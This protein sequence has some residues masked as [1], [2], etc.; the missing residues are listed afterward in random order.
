MLGR[1]LITV[2]ATARHVSAKIREELKTVDP[3]QWAKLPA[4]REVVEPFA[5]EKAKAKTRKVVAGFDIKDF[6]SF[7]GLVIDNETD[8]DL[9]H[10]IRLTTCPL[11]GEAHAG[12]NSTTC[13]FIYPCK[14]GGIAYHCQ[15]TGCCEYGIQEVLESLAKE[16]G[17]YPKKIYEEK[18]EVGLMYR[19]RTLADVEEES[20]I[21]LWPGYLFLK[22]LIHSMG[23]SSEGKSPCW[24]DVIARVTSGANWPDGVEN[25]LGSASVILMAA[26]DDLSD[27]VKP[28]IRLAGGDVAKV[29]L[30]EVLKRK[31]DLQT[32]ISVAIDR[33]IEGSGV[34]AP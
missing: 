6:L 4:E 1:N 21:P 9:G 27:T 32:P 33:D 18:P 2:F 22:Q 20:L 12:H 7:Y 34:L 14:D 26:E 5:R 23:A 30:F 13:N 19:S 25:I 3:E 8:N 10:C 31:D 28:R 15:S 17:P 24:H 29:H 11:K 16:K